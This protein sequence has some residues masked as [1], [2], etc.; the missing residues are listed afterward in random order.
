MR[1]FYDNNSKLYFTVHKKMLT[2]TMPDHVI[3]CFDKFGISVGWNDFNIA[4][5]IW[6][7]PCELEIG[8]EEIL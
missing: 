6:L 4:S 7:S 5:F 3:R 1:L 8:N 2:T